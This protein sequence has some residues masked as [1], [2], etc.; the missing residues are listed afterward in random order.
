MTAAAGVVFLVSCAVLAQ[1]LPRFVAVAVKR[2][3]ASSAARGR[4]D[5]ER[6]TPGS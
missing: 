4:A 1:T 3:W 6:T 5:D 2:A